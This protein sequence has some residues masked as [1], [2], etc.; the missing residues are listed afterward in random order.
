VHDL[1][2]L[3][4]RTVRREQP[5][6]VAG[7]QKDKQKT[8][9]AKENK[10]R[11]K[12][13]NKRKQKMKEENVSIHLEELPLTQY[14]ELTEIYHKQQ[15]YHYELGGSLAGQFLE[16]DI[17]KYYQYLPKEPNQVT[18][19]VA[20]N[21]KN[22]IVGFGTV[23]IIHKSA[24]KI[25]D[26]YVD[27]DYR[28]QKIGE[29]LMNQMNEWITKKKVKT[30]ELTVIKGNEKVIQ[31]YEKLGFNLTGYTMKKRKDNLPYEPKILI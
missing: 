29:K 14:Q 8:S 20:R 25:E 24:A 13:Q 3:A 21:E 31:F 18:I 2:K 26:L 16:I 6:L 15:K 27:S 17:E 10:K 9:K 23:I 11:K 30:V 4:N 22:E 5:F 12:K 7:K 19:Q 1:I 28:G